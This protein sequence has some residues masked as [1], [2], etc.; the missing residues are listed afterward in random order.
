MYEVASFDPSLVDT[1]R[2]T[3]VVKAPSFASTVCRGVAIAFAEAIPT[4]L[5]GMKLASLQGFTA[6]LSAEAILTSSSASILL[7]A[8]L[9]IHAGAKNRLGK[10][11]LY[12]AVSS[13]VCGA[14]CQIAIQ[15]NA[16]LS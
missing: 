15:Y 11:M 10:V 9:L 3:A 5:L 14:I 16:S 8:A 4:F 1:V 7:M 2:E 13:F 12:G 6:G